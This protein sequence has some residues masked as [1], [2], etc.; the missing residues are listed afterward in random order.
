MKEHKPRTLSVIIPV[1]NGESLLRESLPPLL[2]TSA[3]REVIVI[4]DGS[5][6]GS[7]SLARQLGAC[8]IPSGGHALGPA[9]ARNLGAQHASGD[10]LLFVDADVVIDSSVPERILLKFEDDSV[11]AIFGS[12]DATPRERN[13]ASLYMNLR[14]HHGHR[15]PSDNASTFWTGLGAVRREAF[16]A[17]GGFDTARFPLPS[18]E[19]VDLGQRLVA[20][21]SHIHRDPS[22]R[23]THLKRWSWKGVIHTDIFRRAIPWSKM[24]LANPGKFTDLNVGKYEQL[25]ALLA[26]VWFVTMGLALIG[27]VPPGIPI[28]GFALILLANRSLGLIFMKAAGVSFAVA[29]VA[30]HQIH[31]LY[32]GLAYMTCRM[33]YGLSR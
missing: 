19:D 6:D 25:K 3:P 29:G 21:G 23:G 33:R 14:H 11:G 9:A 12:Y 1:L 16:S 8:V 32:S 13:Y 28:A 26:G 7:A 4:D 15:E 17:I 30:F 10:I 20:S 2:P 18:V 24:M 5:T 22:L 27:V 31:F